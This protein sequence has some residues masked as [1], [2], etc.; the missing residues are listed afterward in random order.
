MVNAQHSVW[1][2]KVLYQLSPDKTKWP[3][4]KA[5]Q[6]DKT[7]NIHNKIEWPEFTSTHT[8]KDRYD[9]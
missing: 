9:K 6:N 4:F 1:V 3:A 8:N 2:L 7:G 5:V